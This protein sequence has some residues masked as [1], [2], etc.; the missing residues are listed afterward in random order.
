MVDANNSLIMD[1]SMSVVDKE[2]VNGIIGYLNENNIKFR[3]NNILSFIH[4]SK[5]LRS[6]NRL[7][8][9]IIH[10]ICSYCTL[11]D[12]LLFLTINKQ[13]STHIDFLWKIYINQYYPHSTVVNNL[14]I[15][16]ACDIFNY[17]KINEDSINNF[18]N[19]IRLVE[20]R[21]IKLETENNIINNIMSDNTLPQTK[22]KFNTNKKEII[23]Y[24]TELNKIYNKTDEF[25]I[26]IINK[27]RWLSPSGY[28]CNIPEDIIK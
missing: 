18:I 3:S 25:V 11:Y 6:I 15:S 16:I 17:I 14:K 21:I 19:D 4:K 1:L 26:D 12:G 23:C 5:K 2:I 20:L 9:D 13:F 8:N 28:I 27:F 10:N 22:I 7:S 24:K